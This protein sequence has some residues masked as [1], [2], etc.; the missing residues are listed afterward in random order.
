MEGQAQV[1][2]KAAYPGLAAKQQGHAKAEPSQ[3]GQ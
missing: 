2:D 1:G 3:A